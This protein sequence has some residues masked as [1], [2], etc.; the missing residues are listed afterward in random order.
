MLIEHR[1]AVIC[2]DRTAALVTIA[3]QVIRRYTDEK[4]RRGLLDYD[5]LIDKTHAL[6]ATAHPRWVHYKLDL[7][8]DHVLIDEAQDTSARQW[9]I[10]RHLTAEFSAGAGARGLVKRTVFAV[11]DEKQSIFSFQ[12]AA[13]R[14]YDAMRRYFAKAFAISD[15]LWRYVRFDHSFRSGENVLGAVDE[16]FRSPDIYRSITSDPDGVLG[17]E[18]LPGAMP[19]RVEIWPLIEADPA[20][21]IEPWDAPF[22][23]IAE[24]S[25]QVRLARKI[26]ETVR[27]LIAA[28]GPVGAERKPIGEGDVL[29]LVR[30]RGVLFEAII[31]A[32]KRASIAVAG[33]DRLVL[34][35][36]IAIVDLM[37]LADALLLPQDD[38][39]L[40][41]ALKSPLFGFDE[42]RL[43]ALAYGR[44]RTSLRRT[45]AQRATDDPAFAATDALLNRAAEKAR[46]ETPFGFFAW[47]LGPQQGRRRIY[48]RLGLEAADAL[49]EFLE[50]ARAYEQNETPSL[51]GFLAFLRTGRIEVKRDMDMARGEVRVMTVHG[52]KGLEAPLVILAD[53]TTPPRGTHHPRLVE[54]PP[55]RA[56]PDAPACIAW[57]GRKDSDVAATAAARE[58][59]L[60]EVEHEHRRLLYVAMTRAAERLIVCGYQGKMPRRSGCWYDLIHDAL[61][62]KPGF[63]QVGD[64][65]GRLW[66]Y[67]KAPEPDERPSAQALPG[68]PDPEVPAWL[69]TPV[70][71]EAL[72]AQPLTPSAASGETTA[73]YR[74]VRCAPVPEDVARAMARGTLLHRL[75]Q[76]LPDVAPQR[77]EEAARTFLARGT[78]FSAEER[79][80]FA[81]QALALLAKPGLGLLFVGQSRTEVA[82]VGRIARPGPPLRPDFVVSGQ[83]DR[84]I[85]TDDAVLIADYKTNREPPRTLD[86]APQAYVEQLALYRVLI[87]RIYPDRP[88]R[89]AL[90]WTELPDLMEIPA[91]MLDAA[92][93][94]VLG[95]TTAA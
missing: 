66:R 12:G 4:D 43:F 5:D 29:I 21:D 1:N 2:R 45:L 60:R 33:A 67:C 72:P 20:P 49:D 31:R 80:R 78:S 76:S 3:E 56:V 22:D 65:D 44:G 36:H 23:S 64:G 59:A 74:K 53:T 91:A 95:G 77:R 92:L 83:I 68:T 94:R 40:A 52:A 13:P 38:L 26:A 93:S 8:V 51:Q 54:L 75:L 28:R 32:L 11:G 10:I 50:L 84:L 55:R 70:P 35:E 37:A 63:T 73:L 82:I 25:P 19:G 47:L 34:I 41:I 88:V 58:A 48:A 71:Q 15:V 85:V 46:R 17:H 7:G 18:A 89:A 81:A 62:G 14:Q 87:S 57:A 86:A 30:Q 24:T 39:A 61:Q 9:A 79:E 6:L 90:V 27:D 69:M 16:V 42:D